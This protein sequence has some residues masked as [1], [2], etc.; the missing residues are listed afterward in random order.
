[1][2]KSNAKD[3][4]KQEQ[5]KLF[6]TLEERFANNMKR[7][8]GLSWNEI[9]KKLN[10]RLDLLW[11]INEMEKTGGEP[12]VVVFENKPKELFFC[13][14]SPESPSG[15]R[16]LC[17]DKEALDSRKENKPAG[18]AIQ[19]AA[20]MGV[21]LLNE[22]EYRMLQAVGKFDLKSSSWLKTPDDIRTLGGAIFADC[23]YGK[24]FVYH[25]GVQSYYAGRAFRGLIKL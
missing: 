24:V 18:S 10:G 17:Y 16:S 20:T 11:S 1:M 9:S 14:C 19:M 12:D 25:N 7:H 21:E 3:L 15:R 5:A 4:S 23:R 13:D 22:E 2:G 8:K 6:K